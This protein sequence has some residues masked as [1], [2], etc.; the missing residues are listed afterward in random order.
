[1]KDSKLRSERLEFYAEDMERLHT[2]LDSFLELSKARCALLIDRDGHLVTRR[3]DAVQSSADS[4]SALVAGSFAAT[5][6]MA[7]LLGET[8]FSVMFH[9]G[10]RDSIQLQ[11]V[12]ERTL[13]AVLFDD[14]TNL[15]LVRFYA[16]EAALRLQDVFESIVGRRGGGELAS[17]FSD[18][19]QAALDELF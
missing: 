15:G 10:K 18:V 11:L 8:E 1:M 12:G 9:Q 7:R 13:L 6:E 16:Q 2:E 3:G 4:I 17:N 14:R 19:G 5:K